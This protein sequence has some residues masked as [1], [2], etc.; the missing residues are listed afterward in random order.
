MLLC[1]NC[2]IL[3]LCVRCQAESHI[4]DALRL[5][6]RCVGDAHPLTANALGHL[7]QVLAKQGK[8]DQASPFL[9]EALVLEVHKDAFHTAT[10]FELLSNIK[11]LHTTAGVDKDGKPSL[12]RLHEAYMP[13]VPSIEHGVVRARGH[14]QA[15]DVQRDGDVGALF[16]ISSEVLLLAGR[17][18]K[19]SPILA[20]AI[21]LFERAKQIYDTSTLIQSCRTMA[22]FAR[23]L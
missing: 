1:G 20:E 18:D 3:T 10:V 2:S 17:G 15:G 12:K 6:R 23:E 22:A 7:G 14:L 13:Y 5:F 8:K 19:A 11:E 21:T 4:Q 16:K 9:R